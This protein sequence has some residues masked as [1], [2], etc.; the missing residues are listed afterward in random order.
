[1]KKKLALIILAVVVT[2][3]IAPIA[4][5]AATSVTRP[6]L[7][8]C[9]AADAAIVSGLS[10]DFAITGLTGGS[11]AQLAFLDK[12]GA[13]ITSAKSA[14]LKLALLALDTA[15]VNFEDGTRW[16]YNAP[17]KA[18]WTKVNNIVTFKRCF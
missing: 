6:K 12:V 2:Q 15:I 4:S 14:N 3:V 5:N 18:A 11:D 10:G 8:M 16:S 17:I 7:V 1:M 9:S 13:G